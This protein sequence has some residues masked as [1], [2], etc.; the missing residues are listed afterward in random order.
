MEVYD[1]YMLGTKPA[2]IPLF[3]PHELFSAVWQADCFDHIFG[4]P[5]ACGEFWSVVQPS[6]WARSHP[7][8]ELPDMLPRTVPI[9]MHGDGAVTK[10]LQNQKL[11]IVSIHSELRHLASLMPRLL[12]FAVRDRLLTP[13]SLNVLLGIVAW[14]L[15]VAFNTR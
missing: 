2:K 15:N 5:A 13:G 10:S 7:A 6:K 1:P 9:R 3:L 14:S 8:Y 11:V 12:C 4:D